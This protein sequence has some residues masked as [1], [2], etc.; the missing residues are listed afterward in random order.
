MNRLLGIICAAFWSASC[1]QGVAQD[2]LVVVELY[3][4]QSC[5]SCPPADALLAELNEREGVLPLALHVDYWDYMGWKDHFANP[6]FTAR[7]RA[8]A[9]VAG[10]NSIYTPQMV[11]GGEDH[12]IGAR[13]AE[14][15]RLIDAHKQNLTPVTISAKRQGDLLTISAV[16]PETV[17]GPITIQLVR[18]IP[19]QEVKIYRGENAG[20]QIK[21]TNVVSEWTALGEW[22]GDKLL[23][24]ETRVEG[25]APA[26][27]ILQHEGPGAILAATIVTLETS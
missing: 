4:S 10:A 3:T 14:M 9:R 26:A 1:V 7:Q 23:H 21:Y 2:N 8:Y 5:S 18:F 19:E 11:I 15:N 17:S 27:V 13:R 24:F 6:R 16:P 12:I 22:R 25:T 20:R